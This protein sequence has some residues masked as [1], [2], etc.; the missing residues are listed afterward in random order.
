M[1]KNKA[2][3]SPDS[4]DCDDFAVVSADLDADAVPEDVNVDV[5]SVVIAAAAAVV[6]DDVLSIVVKQNNVSCCR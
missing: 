3:F 2:H 5:N 4:D 6:Y 1:E